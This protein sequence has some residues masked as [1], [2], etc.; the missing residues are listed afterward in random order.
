MPATTRGRVRL[1]V[2]N[3]NGGAFLSQCFD[4]LHRLDWPADELELVLV[5]NASSDGSVEAVEAAHADVRV[6][7]NPENTGFPANNLGLAD[8]DGVRYVGLVNNDGFVEPGW[9]TAL[10]D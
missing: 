8:L 7:R 2:L 6:I 10:V 9:L 1:I 3:Y 5:D 4:A